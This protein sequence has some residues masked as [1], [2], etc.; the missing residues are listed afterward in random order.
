MKPAAIIQ[1]A[2]ADGVILV[3]TSSGSLRATGEQGAVTRWLPVL[4]ENKPGILAALEGAERDPPQRDPAIEARRQRVLA[5]LEA[6]PGTR[7]AVLTDLDAAPGV[8]VL[9]LA[10][11]GRASCELHIPRD[12]YDGVLLL[13]LI[14]KYGVTVH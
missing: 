3:R 6:R 9:A 2:A 5:M 14:E 7:Y 10:I 4:R 13:D 11:R 12:K 8:V 1:E